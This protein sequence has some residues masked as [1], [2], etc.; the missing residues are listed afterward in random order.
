[1]NW[2]S[3]GVGA[4]IGLLPLL[5]SVAYEVPRDPT[6]TLNTA[7]DVAANAGAN[8]DV[9]AQVDGYI[10]IFIN[11]LVGVRKIPFYLD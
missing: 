4:V 9:P 1:M 6:H 5:L 11:G 3:F 8:G 2:I 7:V 10:E